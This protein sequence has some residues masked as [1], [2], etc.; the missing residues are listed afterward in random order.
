MFDAV[1]VRGFTPN[2]DAAEQFSV[3]DGKAAW[4]SPVDGG[5]A[6]YAAPAMYAAF[7][8]PMDLTAHLVEKLIAAPGRH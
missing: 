4:R 8:G 1:Q 5:S 7:G 3:A 2:G 6:N